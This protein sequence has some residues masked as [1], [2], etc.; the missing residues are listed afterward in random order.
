MGQEFS[1]IPVDVA[2]ATMADLR[3]AAERAPIVNLVHPSP[4]SSRTILRPISRDLGLPLK[5]YAEWLDSLRRLKDSKSE[6]VTVLDEIPALKL[7]DFYQSLASDPQAA[8]STGDLMEVKLDTTLT[9]SVSETLANER[10]RPLGENDALK[11][12]RRWL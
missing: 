3:K 5:P 2:A 6:K 12:V 11:W 10:L 4:V 9:V 7:F 1:W 8:A